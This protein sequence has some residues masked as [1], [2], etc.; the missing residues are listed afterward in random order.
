LLIVHSERTELVERE[1][2]DAFDAQAR[3]V[4]VALADLRTAQQAFVAPGQAHG[5]WAMKTGD[6]F[7]AVE[8]GLAGLQQQA[9][10]TDGR[11]SLADAATAVAELKSISDRAREAV[12][13]DQLFSSAD[14]V[15][16]EGTET[17][18]DAAARLD[19]A[20]IAE[21]AG[22]ARAST[23][24]RAQQLRAGAT[25]AAVAALAIGLLA[26]V[27]SRRRADTPA[28]APVG[29]EAPNSLGDRQHASTPDR[30]PA[31]A[32][33]GG[34]DLWLHDRR[35]AAPP[36]FPRESVPVLKQ[37]ADLC[38]DLNRA[39]DVDEMGALLD[40]AATAM[41]AVGIIVWVGRPGGPSLRAI[42]AHGYSRDALARMPSVPRS[43]NN[44]AAAAYRTGVLQIVLARP[45]VSNG[46]LAAPM[47]SAEGC[48]GALTAEIGNGSEASDGVQAL[49]AIF[50]A[51]LAGLLAASVI[52]EEQEEASRVSA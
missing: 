26:W 30:T 11:R 20:R 34:V 4:S 6:F 46:A 31:G 50:A 35:G 38:I 22:G 32:Q 12:D 14:V 45:G 21:R 42:L 43:A 3:D 48:V 1:R 36:T 37:A 24:R 8:S 15:F 52:A 13:E 18:K 41:D 7:G 47:L 16:T 5:F 29:G 17:A 40:R 44:A 33:D 28:T 9:V 19:A 25:A 51:Q 23:A 27:P 39:R 10:T 49:A 2:L